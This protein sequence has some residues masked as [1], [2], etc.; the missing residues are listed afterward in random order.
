MNTNI[1]VPDINTRPPPAIVGTPMPEI[2]SSANFNAFYGGIQEINESASAMRQNYIARISNIMN[3]NSNSKGI[4]SGGANYVECLY[5]TVNPT[6]KNQ[7][8]CGGNKKYKDA[9]GDS[10]K[11]CVFS[12]DE[13]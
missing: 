2:K 13:Y 7:Y 4:S 6:V 5:N 11:G 9:Y 12:Y 10:S 3:D 1:E 8:A